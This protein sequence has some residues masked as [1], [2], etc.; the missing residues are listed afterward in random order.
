[1]DLYSDILFVS[2]MMKSLEY[3]SKSQNS[4]IYLYRLTHRPSRS[5]VDIMGA[6]TGAAGK[7]FGVAHGD[8]LAYLFDAS[9]RFKEVFDGAISTEEDQQTRDIMT[10]LWTN[11]AKHQDPTPYQDEDIPTWTAYDTEK[12]AYMDINE[13]PEIKENLHK[14]RVYFWQRMFW[15]DI[16]KSTSSPAPPQVVPPQP[17]PHPVMTLPYAR[18]PLGFHYQPNVKVFSRPGY[19]KTYFI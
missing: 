3:Q 6:A 17:H 19:P 1:M 13:D 4:P 10:T 11:F 8:D 14:E 12:G 5:L 15:E 7:D 18:N 2:P 16:E 9:P